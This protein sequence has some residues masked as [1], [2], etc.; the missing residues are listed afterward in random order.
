VA[1]CAVGLLWMGAF[2]YI[3]PFVWRAL[4][5]WE[6][7]E[8]PIPANLLQSITREQLAVKRLRHLACVDLQEHRERNAELVIPSSLE[9]RVAEASEGGSIYP[10]PWE[11]NIDDLFEVEKHLDDLN[12]LR[13][14]HMIRIDPR[15][16]TESSL[17]N[18]RRLP[19]S[20][21]LILRID[22]SKPHPSGEPAYRLLAGMPFT[23]V[24]V[25]DKPLPKSVAQLLP[26]FPA[27]HTLQLSCRKV[28]LADDIWADVAL[29]QRLSTLFVYSMHVSDAGM[30]SIA[31]IPRL[32]KICFDTVTFGDQ[33]LMLFPA[34]MQ[35]EMLTLAELHEFG[36]ASLA[37][38]H[39]DPL[40]LNLDGTQ[41]KFSGPGREWL[42]SRK[43]LKHLTVPDRDMSLEEAKAVNA[44]GGPQI[45]TT[46]PCW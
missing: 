17:R 13:R 27:L 8:D 2:V 6:V 39:V 18:I 9:Q 43:R 24:E 25:V 3:A 35:L 26:G 30:S 7:A 4:P 19:G 33:G 12:A 14:I 45:E 16:L 28:H 29:C 11:I 31:R 46:S 10:T 36:D 44:L 5:A 32:K 42:L 23:E 1:T 22:D 15:T 34:S 20:D 38:L 41:V 21:R 40:E 37:A